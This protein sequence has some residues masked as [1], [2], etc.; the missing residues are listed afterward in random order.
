M[1]G[2]RDT[3]R[4]GKVR[5]VSVGA[6]W[7]LLAMVVVVGG[8]LA[9]SRLPLDVPGRAAAAYWGTGALTAVGLVA[10]VLAHEAA[11]ALVARRAGLAVGGITLSWLGGVTRMEGDVPGPAWE[12]AVAGAG[13]LTSALAGGA[14]LAARAAVAGPGSGRALAAA[15]LLWLAA[16]DIALAVFNLMP[17]TPLDGGR[18]V[19]ATLWWLT[20]DPGRASTTT[21]R[22]S[23]VVGLAVVAAGAWLLVGRGRPADGLAVGLLGWWVVGAAAAE[24]R[25]SA[26]AH[27]LDG[28]TVAHLMRPVAAAPGAL[29]VEQ[30]ADGLAAHRPGWVWLLHGG[31]DRFSA[32]VAGD[33]ALATPRAM[34]AAVRLADV[35]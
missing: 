15:A 31:D 32:V 28:A 25:S 24:A 26:A 29:T 1:L 18:I 2:L 30:F 35:A 5:G 3:V 4:F 7:S 27:C 20:H 23:R 22:V 19:H 33:A 21:A 13:P 10:G 11:H 17:A 14:A 6:H 34:W 8:G 12:A 16:I 9:R